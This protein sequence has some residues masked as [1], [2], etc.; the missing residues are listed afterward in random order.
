MNVVRRTGA[1]SLE[2]GLVGLTGDV[3]TYTT[4]KTRLIIL[5]RLRGSLCFYR[6]RGARLFSLTRPVPNP[7]AKFCS[8]LTT[9]GSVILIASLFRGHT[10]KLCRGA[11]IIF[12]HSNDVTKGCQG[13][14]VPSSPTCCRG[15]CF[16]PNSVNFRPVRASLNGLKILIY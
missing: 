3:R 12:R 15:F 14:R 11:T 4:R 9:T 13:V 6:A 8:R 10:P 5:R 1:G 16:A 2:A 7:S